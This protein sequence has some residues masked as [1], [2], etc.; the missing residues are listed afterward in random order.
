MAFSFKGGIHPDYN[1]ERTYASPIEVLPPTEEMYLP[2]SQHIGAPCTPTV[3]PGDHVKMGQ[4]IADNP[5]AMACPIH[6]PV[7]G[8]FRGVVQHWHPSGTRQPTMVIENDGLDTVD[9]SLHPYEGDLDDLTPADIIQFAR[10]SGTVGMG[11]AAFPLHV[12]L[13]TALDKKIETIIINGSECEPFITADH[14]A[15]V[16]Y[17]ATIINGVKLIMKCLNKDTAVVAIESNKPDAIA[18]M[19]KAAE[20][21]D[22]RICE[23]P[24][25]YPQGGEKQLIKAITGREIP[26]GKLPMDIGC[27]VFNVDTCASLFRYVSKGRPLTKR[28]CTVSGSAVIRPANLLVRIG[29]PYYALFDYCNGF[30]EDPYKIISGGP[31]MGSAQ[32]ALETPVVKNTSALLAFCGDEESFEDNPT[33]TRCGKC[34]EVCPMRLLPTYIYQ[35]ALAEE[36][37]ECKKLNV[38][39]CIECGCCSYVCPGKLH[40]VQ[41]MRMAKGNI[42]KN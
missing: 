32:H 2:L 17:P 42:P 6:S 19:S 5:V 22:I 31:M 29:T 39:D 9:E 16:E 4:I 34:I 14:R 40:L 11:G 36:F 1:K 21:S 23:L 27:A 8:R 28:V 18:S 33:C 38:T 30:V 15:M 24:T 25:K 26:P 20:D 3:Q 35:H 10:A 37:A 13:K 7:S 41:A 12:K